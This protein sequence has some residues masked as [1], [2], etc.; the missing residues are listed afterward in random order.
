MRSGPVPPKPATCQRSLTAG[1][2]SPHCNPWKI[3][4]CSVGPAT[5]LWA[6]LR[7]SLTR[8]YSRDHALHLSL[9][10][11]RQA[12]DAFVWPRGAL[13]VRTARAPG[14]LRKS[15]CWFGASMRRH[16]PH[17]SWRADCPR[18]LC[19]TAGSPASKRVPSTH[20]FAGWCA[21][22]SAHF[23]TAGRLLLSPRTS[24]CSVMLK[25]LMRPEI[26]LCL[27]AAQSFLFI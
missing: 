13:D 19:K 11:R 23:H 6:R 26:N 8:T 22:L 24:G 12:A 2:Y 5:L 25:S 27:E 17:I 3:G 14:S 15:S 10:P 20:D 7:L 4:R 18:A 9:A 1:G 21:S 16:S